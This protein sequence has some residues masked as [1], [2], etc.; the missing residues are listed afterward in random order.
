MVF[1]YAE[2]H[3]EKKHLS[4]A[5]Y[6]PVCIF[7]PNNAHKL[8][9]SNHFAA[10]HQVSDILKKQF[11]IISVQA[12]TSAAMLDL[13]LWRFVSLIMSHFYST[14]STHNAVTKDMHPQ[15]WHLMVTLSLPCKLLFS[16]I[17]HISYIGA[18]LCVK[19]QDPD[20][21]HLVR[22]D[23]LPRWLRAGYAQAN[24]YAHTQYTQMAT[25]KMWPGDG[26]ADYWF[27]QINDFQPGHLTTGKLHPQ[28]W[29]SGLARWHTAVAT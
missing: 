9:T 11:A 28:S 14:S 16:C 18:M 1:T 29:H 26:H 4:T 12:D 13:H 27:A 7:S 17:Q 23:G 21:G 5:P 19:W 15:M 24:T 8:T 10:N 2:P 22:T 3:S 6:L 20:G 25:R